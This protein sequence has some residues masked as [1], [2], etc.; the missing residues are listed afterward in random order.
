[1][2]FLPKYRPS[3]T[4]ALFVIVLTA[5][6]F[7]LPGEPAEITYRTNVDEVRL[8]FAATDQNNHA[9]ATLEAGDFAVV[10]NDL[11]VRNFRSFSRADYTR[12][13]LAI[14]IDSSESISPRFRQEVADV[15]EL[16]SRTGGVP[17]Q[18][19]SLFSFHGSQPAQ[20]CAGDCRTSRASD[21]LPSAQAG[22]LTP[23]FDSVVF[24]SEFLARH[25]DPQAKKIM[26][27]FS[28]GED[29]VSRNSFHDAAN[30][31]VTNN[32]QIYCIDFGS[33]SSRGAAVL[34]AFAGSSGGRYLPAQD[35]AVKALNAILEDFRA[36]YTVSYR[37]P[38][39]AAGFHPVRILP[40]H[41]LTLQF[42]S[43]SGYYYTDNVR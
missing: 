15:L 21:R 14:L 11:I 25:A 9:V 23:L 42:R 19:V 5:V 6:S 40:T 22:G 4:L 36:S 30:V 12:L 13:E 26:I 34:F 1:M 32:V 33:P 7:G 35:G 16:L 18:N 20:L 24:T 29:T 27:L 10:D 41:D 28:D 3:S 39:R 2:A 17:D 31:A 43:R 38:N 37:L 8:T